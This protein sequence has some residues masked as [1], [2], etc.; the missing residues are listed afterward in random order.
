[1]LSGL[2]SFPAETGNA[3]A[4]LVATAKILIDYLL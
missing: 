4:W 1:V 3:I 2:S